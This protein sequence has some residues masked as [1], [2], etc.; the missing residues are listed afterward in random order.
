VRCCCLFSSFLFCFPGQ[1]QCHYDHPVG[2]S[3]TFN[4]PHRTTTTTKIK[5]ENATIHNYFTR[6]AIASN[7]IKAT[8]FSYIGSPFTYQVSCMH[9]HIHGVSSLFTRLLSGGG[10]STGASRATSI[11]DHYPPAGLVSILV[12]TPSLN[13]VLFKHTNTKKQKHF[14]F[15][16][17]WDLYDRFRSL[18]ADNVEHT[19]WWR[20]HSFLKMPLW[21]R[22]GK[23]E[24]SK[25]YRV[26]IVA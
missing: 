12:K 20:R 21:R 14:F 13:R 8:L 10:H 6:H 19:K 26:I 3:N 4:P 9:I 7:R 16:L 23:T 24:S 11:E 25:L 18:L 2:S 22:G 5:K 17:S 1:P 15:F